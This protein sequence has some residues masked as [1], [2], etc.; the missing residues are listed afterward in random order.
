[1]QFNIEKA[2]GLLAH[3]EALPPLKG[4]IVFKMPSPPTEVVHEELEHLQLLIEG[5]FLQ[6]TV[7]VGHK[8]IP[9]VIVV[10]RLTL[11]G[12]EFLSNSREQTAWNTVKGHAAKSGGS[13]ALGTAVEVLK[14]LAVKAITGA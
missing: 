6:G 14:A 13:I 10:D 3:V 11:A 8:Q 1:M 9:S 4:C 7:H 12:H 2:L 5:G